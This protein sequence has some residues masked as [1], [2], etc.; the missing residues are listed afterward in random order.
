T[1][2]TED[3]IRGFRVSDKEGNGFVGAGELRYVLTQLEEKMSD[4]ELLKGQTLL[5]RC[6]SDGNVS[7]ESVVC[8]I[9][10]Q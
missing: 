5:I 10:S 1:V 8:S 4:E 7:Y 3:F 9:L 2:P 6:C